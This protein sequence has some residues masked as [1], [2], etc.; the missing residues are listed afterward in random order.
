MRNRLIVLAAGLVFAASVASVA[1]VAGRGDDATSGLEKLPFGAA[2]SREAAMAAEQKS[3][4]VLSAP[5]MVEY[6]LSG[7]LPDLPPTAPAYRLTSAVTAAEVKRLARILGL[8]GDVVE[9]PE[10]LVV[11]AGERELAVERQ[12]GLPWYLGYGVSCSDSPVSSETGIPLKCAATGS[13]E[14]RVVDDTAVLGAIPPVQALVPPGAEPAPAVAKPVP[15]PER[16]PGEPFCPT[17]I[18]CGV[19]PAPPVRPSDLPSRAE[20]GAQARALFTALG[21]GL[22]SFELSDGFDAWYASVQPQVGGLD[23]GWSVSVA[24]GPKGVLQWANGFL[25]TPERMGDYPL[26]GTAV[27]FERLQ[28]GASSYG[29]SASASAYGDGG[30]GIAVDA[31]VAPAPAIAPA[32]DIARLEPA[33]TFV[34]TITGARLALQ[35]LGERLVPVYRFLLS[36]GGWV[37][38]PA[39]VDELLEDHIADR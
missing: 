27:G 24:I 2:P 25:A 35:Y 29:W 1:V 12:P 9:T 18:G 14:V 32:P 4:A 31:M 36:D 37:E 34:Q 28:R 22:D 23:V 11:R 38:A 19:P 15:A 13:S 21:V 33:G 8:E 10:R 26:A 7:P 20:A 5:V 39:V 30:G 6:R 17:D 3:D 16:F